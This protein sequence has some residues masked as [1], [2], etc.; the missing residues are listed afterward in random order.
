VPG[1]GGGVAVGKE[2]VS[3]IH[4]AGASI[5]GA[6]ET[7]ACAAPGMGGGAT[8]EEGTPEA[9]AGGPATMPD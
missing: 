2:G 4:G 5:L 6:S 3:G 9:A 8:P 1:I 7:G